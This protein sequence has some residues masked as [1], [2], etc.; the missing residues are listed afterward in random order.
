[1]KHE[2]KPQPK[3]FGNYQGIGDDECVS[4][5]ENTWCQQEML[6]EQARADERAKTLKDVQKQIFNNEIFCLG[7]LISWLKAEI[8]KEQKT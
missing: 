7:N 6:I 3:C 5:P 2:Q 1:M 8:K 4:C